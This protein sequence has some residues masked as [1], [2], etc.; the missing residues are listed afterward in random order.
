MESS[1]SFSSFSI[2]CRRM[3][4]VSFSCRLIEDLPMLISSSQIAKLS[5]R[6]SSITR[7]SM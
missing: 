4:K 5:Y 7:S 1:S 2:D 3:L 6:F